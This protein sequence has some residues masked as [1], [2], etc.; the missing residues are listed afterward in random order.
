MRDKCTVDHKY[1]IQRIM[2]ENQHCTN[3]DYDTK[4]IGKRSVVKF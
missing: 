2:R 1:I 3:Y 4:R